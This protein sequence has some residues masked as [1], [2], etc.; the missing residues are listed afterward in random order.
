M[1]ARKQTPL[2]LRAYARLRK[3]SAQAVVVA[4]RRGRLRASVIRDAR[5]HAKIADVALANREWAA[6]TDL[7][8][9]PAYVKERAAKGKGTKTGTLAAAVVEEKQWRAKRAQLEYQRMSGDLVS[10]KQV[11][12]SLTDLLSRFRTKVLGLPSKAKQMIPALAPADVHVLDGLCR[13]M[14]EEL[15]AMGRTTDGTAA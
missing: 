12:A 2:S 14:L 10:A 13:E 3:V 9:A 6:N 8:K 15:A 7:T 4:V 1:S 11:E 5:G